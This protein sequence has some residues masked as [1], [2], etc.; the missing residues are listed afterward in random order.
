MSRIKAALI[1]DPDRRAELLAYV[2]ERAEILH[3]VGDQLWV[4]HDGDAG[5]PVCRAGHPAAATAGCRRDQAACS[6]LRFRGWRLGRSGTSFLRSLVARG[7]SGVRL[8]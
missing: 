7:L 8:W 5:E 1:V 4:L 3:G 6:H 2:S